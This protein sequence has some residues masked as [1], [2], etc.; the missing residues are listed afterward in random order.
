MCL[1]WKILSQFHEL[2]FQT[3]KGGSMR[4]V[5]SLARF[6]YMRIYS[7]I[8]NLSQGRGPYKFFRIHTARA[9]PLRSPLFPLSY[10]YSR[11]PLSSSSFFPFL[12]HLKENCKSLIKINKQKSFQHDIIN[13]ISLIGTNIQFLLVILSTRIDLLGIFIINYINYKN[14]NSKAN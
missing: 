10:S 5:E 12:Y 7:S 8:H 13:S 14:I 9:T 11:P 4:K 3:R 2:L 6:P 1:R